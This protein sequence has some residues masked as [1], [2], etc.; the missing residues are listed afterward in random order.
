MNDLLIEQLAKEAGYLPDMF[1]IGHWHSQE[2]KKLVALTVKEVFDRIEYE[3][4][5]M[6][7]PV[8]QR[9]EQYFGIE[10]EDGVKE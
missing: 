7:A 1:G 5:A 4:F 6:Y 10:V 8:K 3:R 2:C 9:V